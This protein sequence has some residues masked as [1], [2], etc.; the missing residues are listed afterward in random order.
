MQLFFSLLQRGIFPEVASYFFS[1][2][3]ENVD[4]VSFHAQYLCL[5]L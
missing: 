5:Q 1:G 2:A 3:Q 4:Q